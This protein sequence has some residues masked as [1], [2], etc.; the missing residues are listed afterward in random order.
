VTK[1]VACRDCRYFKRAPYEAPRTGCWFP[2]FMQ[3]TQ[4]DA[5]L[6]EQEIPGD[7]EQ[8]NLRGDCAKFDARAPKLSILKRMLAGEF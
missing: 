6:K 5:F 7:P 2:E 8:L 3:Q 4:K 1:K